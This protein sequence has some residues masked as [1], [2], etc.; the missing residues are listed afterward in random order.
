MSTIERDHE[1]GGERIPITKGAPAVLMQHCNR[2]RIGMDVVP[3]DEVQ[4]A[5]AHAD[6]ERLSDEASRTLVVAYRPLGADEDPKASE[7]LER[8]LI[9]VGTVG[10]IDRRARKRRSR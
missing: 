5:H 6:V 4:R 7:T 2:I 3:P 8:D 9:F 1:H 10:I